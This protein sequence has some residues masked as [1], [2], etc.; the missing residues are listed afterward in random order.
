MSKKMNKT[1]TY[2]LIIITISLLAGCAIIGKN[3][4]SVKEEFRYSVVRISTTTQQPYFYNPWIWQ[5]PQRTSGQGLVVGKD[6]VLT[7]ASVVKNAKLIEMTMESEPVPTPME[8]VVID[9]ESNLAL[10]RGKLPKNAKPVEIPEKSEFINSAKLNIFWKTSNGMIISGN[11][12]L[13]RAETRFNFDSFQGLSMYQ[14]VKSS[15]ANIG[16]GVP[17]FDDNNKFFGLSLRG[18]DEYN[19]YIITCDII[20]RTL[21]IKNASHKEPTSI[22]GFSSSA[23]NQVYYRKKLGLK[24]ESGGCLISKVFGQGSGHKQ[25]KVGD[26]L[27]SICGNPLDAWGRYEN[28]KHGAMTYTHLF[29]EKYISE[30]FPVTIIRN[31]KEI[32]LDLKLSNIDDSKW[33]I[34]ENPEKKKTQYFVRGGFVFIPLTKTYLREWGS[35]FF[36]KA[37]LDLVSLYNENRYKIKTPKLKEIVILTRVLSH[38][39]NIGLQKINNQ[40]V[41]EVNGKPL[42]SLEELYSIMNN[43]KEDVLKLTLD[44]GDSPLVLSKK[45]LR[46]A[47]MEIKNSYG[48]GSLKSID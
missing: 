42:K 32:K 30:N 14:A 17:V 22:A 8:I 46:S 13:D 12:V 41:K 47:D 20:S 19:F 16:Y 45:V 10:L 28:K 33:L 37:P 29:S 27:L 2:I 25:L 34:P 5:P 11:A 23:L 36:N 44:P 38:P 3:R 4:T 9:L 18:K 40:I 39:S 31:K 26:V 15:Q 1:C 7:L 6:L 24:E 43:Y 35:D 48:I 21:D